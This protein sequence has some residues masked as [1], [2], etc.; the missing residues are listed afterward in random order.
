MLWMQWR[1]AETKAGVASKAR[2]GS[3]DLLGQ[4]VES[5]A[6]ALSLAVV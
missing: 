1:V 6:K 3:L 2:L 5:H 4:A